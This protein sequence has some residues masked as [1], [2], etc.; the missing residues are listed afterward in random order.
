MMTVPVLNFVAVMELKWRSYGNVV[1]QPLRAVWSLVATAMNA[2][3]HFSDAV[4]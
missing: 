3:F 4:L 2:R 1:S